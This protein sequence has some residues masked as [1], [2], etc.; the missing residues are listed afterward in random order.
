MGWLWKRVYSHLLWWRKSGTEQIMYRKWMEQSLMLSSDNNN[1]GDD[2]DDDRSE[3]LFP[4][5]PCGWI[6]VHMCVYTW[7]RAMY[8]CVCIARQHTWVKWMK[9]VQ[10]FVHT[11]VCIEKS[12]H[13]NRNQICDAHVCDKVYVC[14]GSREWGGERHCE[15]GEEQ[16]H[17]SVLPVR[18]SRWL[19]LFEM[20]AQRLLLLC[21][22]IG[23]HL[24]NC[25]RRMRN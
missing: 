7:K 3:S 17:A 13:A 4:H 15:N 11:Q 12:T 23:Q 18:R 5:R 6:P 2:D 10:M 8:V 22:W 20:E 21:S 16:I 25:W 1:D 24:Q 14:G 19:K 9:N